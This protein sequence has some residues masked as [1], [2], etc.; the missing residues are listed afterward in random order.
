MIYKNSK[1]Y[2]IVNSKSNSI[3]IGST[4][5]SLARRMSVHRAFARH[6]YK[7]G[8]K[9]LARHM[10]KYGVQ[11]FRIVLIETY[12]CKNKDELRAREE[13]WIEKLKPE[14]NIVS[15]YLTKEK[16]KEN[17]QKYYK[18]HSK[19]IKKRSKQWYQD[20]KE[21]AKERDSIYRE[22][23]KDKILERE[24]QIICCTCGFFCSYKNYARHV[25]SKMHFE[26]LELNKHPEQ[27]EK[28]LCDCGMYCA[29][30][31][32]KIHLQSKIHE[33]QLKHLEEYF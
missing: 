12:P 11:N 29:K 6:E 4:T 17:W 26:F 21:Y 13:Y 2:K 28:I 22:K 8:C 30:R 25:K 7:C 18:Q 27:T 9:K 15:A 23:N 14:L 3:Y 16:K 31:S 1:I 20:N 19:K 24:E 5:Q 33:R 10:Q 32:Y